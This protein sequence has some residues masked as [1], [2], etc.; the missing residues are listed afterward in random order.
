[1]VRKPL[2]LHEEIVR[3]YTQVLHESKHLEKV[4]KAIIERVIEQSMKCKQ[5][6]PGKLNDKEN[7]VSEKIADDQAELKVNTT[8]DTKTMLHNCMDSELALSN[9]YSDLLSFFCHRSGVKEHSYGTTAR[10]QR[11]ISAY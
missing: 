5:E 3:R 10:H 1:M 8:G 11:S 4:Q 2:H 7:N 9:V 6:L